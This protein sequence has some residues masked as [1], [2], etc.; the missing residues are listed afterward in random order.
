MYTLTWCPDLGLF[1]LQRPDGWDGL[2]T[3]SELT[4]MFKGVG[5][6]LQWAAFAMAH[7]NTPCDYDPL[8]K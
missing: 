4:E 3:H 1:R 7:G 2:L 8:P 5:V 6:L